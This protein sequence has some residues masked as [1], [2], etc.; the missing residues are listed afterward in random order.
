MKIRDKRQK[1]WFIVD[2]IYL[3]GYAKIFGPI[4][5]SVYIS[6][7][8]HVD[9]ETQKCF[10]SMATIAEEIG[11]SRNTISKYIKML[12][13]YNLI[14]VVETYDT[15]NKKR[16]NNVYTLLDKSEWKAKPCTNAGHGN[17]KPCTNGDKSHAQPLGSNNT[18]INNTHISEQSSRGLIQGN[19][20]NEAIDSFKEINPM[21]EEFY[22]NTTE[23]KAIE[24]L[25]EKI[26]KEKLL[27][28]LKAL[29]EIIAQPYAPKITKPTELKRDLGKL[30][31][32]LKQNKNTINKYQITKIH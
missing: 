31:T 26:G 13:E 17:E 24:T 2:N 21:Y 29:P 22:K 7:C 32:F 8:R 9:N 27:N 30:V 16:K 14:S 18:H 10:P 15:K 20:W 1:E 6:L 5:T 23:R 12:E 11:S 4:G 19:E 25:A 3:N 28:L